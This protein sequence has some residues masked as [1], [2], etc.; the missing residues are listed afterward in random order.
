MVSQGGFAGTGVVDPNVQLEKFRGTSVQ[1]TYNFNANPKAASSVLGCQSIGR[2]YLVSKNVC[3]RVVVGE[4]G[5]GAFDED[6]VRCSGLREMNRL[7]SLY[8]QVHEEEKKVHDVLAACC[9][10]N[11]DIGDWRG[12]S[13]YN[14]GRAWGTRNDPETGIHIIRDYSQE[15]FMRTLLAPER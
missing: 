6:D 7:L 10:I 2:I 14:E 1:P 8:F 11:P 5:F 3:H 12:V 9:A 15:V 13:V 4:E